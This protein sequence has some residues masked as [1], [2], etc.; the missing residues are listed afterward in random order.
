M[1]R[2][3]EC[4]RLD[5][6]QCVMTFDAADTVAV[7]VIPLSDRGPDA[8]SLALRGSTTVD[9]LWCAPGCAPR[10]VEQHGRWAYAQKPVRVPSQQEQ[11]YP[12][13]RYHGD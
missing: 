10:V 7:D 5:G 8:W 3:C 1:M 2:V 11:A 4:Q 13:N 9:C 12:E 6:G